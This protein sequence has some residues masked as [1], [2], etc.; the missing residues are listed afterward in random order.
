[1][2]VISKS[3]INNLIDIVKNGTP[4]EQS[5]VA[6]KVLYIH[7]VFNTDLDLTLF[8]SI[9][10]LSEFIPTLKKLEN[11]N[12]KAKLLLLAFE[13]KLEPFSEDLENIE[14]ST[15]EFE[16]YN[17]FINSNTIINLLNPVELLFGQYALAETLKENSNSRK[18][19]H[20]IYNKNVPITQN[21]GFINENFKQIISDLLRKNEC[22]IL[23]LKSNEID[24]EVKFTTLQK[25]FELYFPPQINCVY[26]CWSHCIKEN[27]I[28]NRIIKFFLNKKFPASISWN[29]EVTLNTA[30]NKFIKNPNDNNFELIKMLLEYGAN[31]NDCFKIISNTSLIRLLSMQAINQKKV[32]NQVNEILKLYLEK[33]ANVNIL[34]LNQNSALYYA[35][36][37]N[38]IEAVKLLLSHNALFHLPNN[39]KLSAF[40]LALKCSNREIIYLFLRHGADKLLNKNE[41]ISLYRKYNFEVRPLSEN[42]YKKYKGNIVNCFRRIELAKKLLNVEAKAHSFQ[43]VV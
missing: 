19:T 17:E 3:E 9:K 5:V 43:I 16:Y 34:N 31:T 28:S 14:F 24:E 12:K 7:G 42:F 38:N 27:L 35:V 40:D 20:L 37:N 4:L 21:F 30:I 22:L 29:L 26:H 10:D 1:M 25:I 15:S 23:I 2:Q 8:K 39:N 41:K 18:L 33:G 13:K 32:N 6:F 11:I 36:L